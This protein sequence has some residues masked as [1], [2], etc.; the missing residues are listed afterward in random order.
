MMATGSSNNHYIPFIAIMACTAALGVQ[1]I[2]VHGIPR[3]LG[4]SLVLIT[5]ATII[6]TGLS[7]RQY[8][9]QSRIPV[10]PPIVAGVVLFS[11]FSMT[12]IRMGCPGTSLVTV[13]LLS[14]G[15]YA[16]SFYYPPSFL[17]DQD[18]S[19]ALALLRSEIQCIDG[20][21]VWIDYGYVP[22]A[23]TGIKL[24][25]SPSWV[26]IEDIDR[27]EISDD[28]RHERLKPLVDH[29]LVFTHIL[30]SCSPFS[31]R[32]IAAKPTI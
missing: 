9:I 5:V 20:D 13:I 2:V 11:Y 25:R 24:S 27:Q 17:S 7:I 28:A 1:F 8:G 12:R 29:M 23:L 21:V 3:W 15:Q 6:V 22:S 10:Y 30:Q 14:I 16:A 32:V 19:V 4:A 18:Y 26:A 31:A